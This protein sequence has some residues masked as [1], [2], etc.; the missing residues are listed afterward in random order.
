MEYTKNLKSKKKN[1]NKKEIGYYSCWT[2]LGHMQFYF[3]RLSLKIPWRLC[4]E[5]LLDDAD[6][7][8]H[9]IKIITHFKEIVSF[10]FFLEIVFVL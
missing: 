1:N 3:Y 4:I 9:K 5:K 2:P 10:F 6:K 7:A 8:Q